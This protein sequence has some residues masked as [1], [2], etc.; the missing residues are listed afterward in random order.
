MYYFIILSL[1]QSKK[2]ALISESDIILFKNFPHYQVWLLGAS[3][4]GET[5]PQ[6][7]A[8]EQHSLCPAPVASSPSQG[9]QFP[10][11]LQMGNQAAWRLT[12]APVHSGGSLTTAAAGSLYPSMASRCPFGQTEDHRVS[13]S[14]SVSALNKATKSGMGPREALAASQAEQKAS[15]SPQCGHTPAGLLLH[16]RA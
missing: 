4:K 8:T 7:W 15:P 5:R 14:I 1:P 16:G 10:A 11:T 12:H 13:P 3:E 2:I 6:P 9:G